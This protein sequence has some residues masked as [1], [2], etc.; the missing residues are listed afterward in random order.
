MFNPARVFQHTPNAI[1]VSYFKIVM[2]ANEKASTRTRSAAVN[3][4]GS[5]MNELNLAK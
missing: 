5:R 2:H 4:R 1:K 3:P